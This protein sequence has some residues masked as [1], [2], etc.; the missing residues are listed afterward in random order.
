MGDRGWGQGSTCASAGG[1]AALEAGASG[2]RTCAQS[3]RLRVG[4]DTRQRDVEG[5]LTQSRK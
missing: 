3:E 2:Q 5:S 1:C 4:R